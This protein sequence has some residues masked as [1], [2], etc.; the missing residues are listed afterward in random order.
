[1]RADI[2]PSVASP[3]YELTDHTVSNANLRIGRDL[4][5]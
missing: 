5:R 1:M 2:V 3:E 4:I